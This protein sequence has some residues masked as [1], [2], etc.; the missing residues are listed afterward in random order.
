MIFRI[1]PVKTF[2]ALDAALPPGALP[3]I[4]VV[5]ALLLVLAV[6]RR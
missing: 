6:I 5:V 4:G 2:R 3:V 1:V